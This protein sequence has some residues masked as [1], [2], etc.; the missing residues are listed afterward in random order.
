[1][2]HVVKDSLHIRVFLVSKPVTRGMRNRHET[3]R[4]DARGQPVCILECPV[5]VGDPCLYGSRLYFTKSGDDSRHYLTQRFTDVE[6][7][8][9]RDEI[10]ISIT[11]PRKKF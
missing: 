1:T 6:T 7:L 3:E 8:G 2:G 9:S 4:R 10:F 5:R 11:T